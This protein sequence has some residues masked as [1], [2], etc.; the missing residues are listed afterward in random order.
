MH[1]RAKKGRAALFGQDDSSLFEFALNL[2]MVFERQRQY[3]KAV[4]HYRSWLYVARKHGM[5]LQIKQIQKVLD[6]C[7]KTW[8]EEVE[9]GALF[10]E[11]ID[12]N[13][14]RKY[15]RW[16]RLSL[17]EAS[18]IN[19][20]TS[21]YTFGLV[22]LGKTRLLLGVKTMAIIIFGKGLDY[23]TYVLKR[24]DYPDYILKRPDYP[25][26]FFLASQELL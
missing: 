24:P 23:P 22:L 5:E 19:T 14:L 26:V 10:R 9:R 2:G 3:E 11:N 18:S 21:F 20:Y 15:T 16:C 8:T 25:L 13:T 17:R 4:E 7:L 6:K 1:E 12:E